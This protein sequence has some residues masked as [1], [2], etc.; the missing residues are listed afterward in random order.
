MVEYT[1][2]FTIHIHDKIGLKRVVDNRLP[3]TEMEVT[4][5]MQ[6]FIN[7][8]SLAGIWMGIQSD[9]KLDLSVSS[10]ASNRFTDK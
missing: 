7:Y 10:G 9:W 6:L 4:I 3:V 2:S 5:N 8:S 1:S